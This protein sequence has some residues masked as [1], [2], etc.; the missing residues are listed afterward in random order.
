MYA[1]ILIRDICTWQVGNANAKYILIILASYTN[2][3]GYCFPSIPTLISKTELSRS[4]V[5]RAL[6]WC[7]YNK[8]LVRKS[9]RTGIATSYQFTCLME[10]IM[11]E[12]HEGSVNMTPQVISNV[13]NITDNSNTTWGSNMTL[14]FDA[15]WSVYPRRVAKGH[16]R[17]AFDKACKLA[18]AEQIISAA[19]KFSEVSADTDKQYIPHPTTWLNGERWDDDLDDV[20][21]KSKSNSD[22]LDDILSGMTVNKLAI[23]SD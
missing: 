12:D 22:Y 4:T 3:D 20:A 23:E 21:P 9:G 10:D 16:A 8:Y 1:D 15:F 5:I 18:P 2:A 6:N 11:S 17:K 14:P 13:I 19:A 7:V